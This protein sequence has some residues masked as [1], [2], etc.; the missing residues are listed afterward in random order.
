MSNSLPKVLITGG[1]GQLASTLQYHPLA[2]AFYLIVLSREELDITQPDSIKKAIEMHQPDIIINTAAY[3]AVDEAESEAE[4]AHQVNHLGAKQLAIACAEKNIFLLHLSTDY[5]FDGAQQTSY[6][7]ACAATPINVYG[8][9]KLLGEQAVRDICE[10][11]IILRVSGVF[12]EYGHNFVKT[13][14]RLAREQDE[15]RVVSDQV[16]CPTYAGDIAA[17]IYKILATEALIYGTYH[18]CSRDA[19]SWHQF[20]VSIVAEAETFAPVKTQKIL[21]IPA[22]D[23]SSAAKRPVYSA[24]NCD[25][26]RF[27][28]DIE[29]P[30]TQKAI[31]I[32]LSIIPEK[33]DA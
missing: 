16:S 20:A 24:L 1:R 5:I 11:H 21:P 33:F 18:F 32:M 6:T 4:Q 25:K 19:V 26:I 22:T 31:Q 13:I 10:R 28:Y 7:E 8:Q 2:Y 23:Y 29:Q 3:T 12:S 15:L 30:G 27:T 17:A 9:S 14:L